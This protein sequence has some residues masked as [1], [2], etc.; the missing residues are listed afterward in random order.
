MFASTLPSLKG[1]LF[2]FLSFFLREGYGFIFNVLLLSSV[3]KFY[4][5]SSVPLFLPSPHMVCTC[6]REHLGLCWFEGKILWSLGFAHSVLSAGTI[7]PT[8][9]DVANLSTFISPQF[10]PISSRKPFLT[11]FL[12]SQTSFSQNPEITPYVT[13]W[14]MKMTSASSIIL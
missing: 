1:F 7:F 4:F 14:W 2:L 6:K 13:P 12:L 9:L 3:L 11:P 10:D 8:L 5:T